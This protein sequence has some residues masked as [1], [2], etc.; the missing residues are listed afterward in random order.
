VSKYE[1]PD[2]FTLYFPPGFFHAL[3]RGARETQA[4]M[5]QALYYLSQEEQ[6]PALN[7]LDQRISSLG[8]RQAGE[9]EGD[10]F[11]AYHFSLMLF[12]FWSKIVFII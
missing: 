9:I 10:S 5:M 3:R 2:L 1:T 6:H 8:G 12:S 7:A 11:F 4:Q